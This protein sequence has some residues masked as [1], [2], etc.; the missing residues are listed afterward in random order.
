MAMRTERIL[1][2][3]YVLMIAQFIA[4]FISLKIRLAFLFFLFQ[5][6]AAAWFY[7]SLK[8]ELREGEEFKFYYMLSL[9]FGFPFIGIAIYAQT[10]SA[11]ANRSGSS[12]SELKKSIED[13]IKAEW[14]PYT[15]LKSPQRART[16]QNTAVPIVDLLS[17]ENVDVKRKS[18]IVLHKMR[19]IRAIVLLKHAL[20][21]SNVEIKFM[22]ASAL[23]SIENELK[24][25]IK[26]LE[27]EIEIA[28]SEG[29][30][31]IYELRY[32]LATVISK[33]IKSKL[34]DE[35]SRKALHDQ[36]ISEL[37]RA[38]SENPD[39]LNAK[40]L[41]AEEYS[42][43]GMYQEALGIL[44]E[45]LNNPKVSSDGGE[46]LKISAVTLYCEIYYN[47]SDISKLKEACGSI[48]KYINESLV[49]KYPDLEGF[50]RSV[51]YF[52]GAR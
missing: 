9:V 14:D 20:N 2:Y 18:I 25:K 36:M 26:D 46:K 13:Y 49:K 51:E 37:S 7:F 3:Q 42:L 24:K 34:L 50:Y 39:H 45:I 52:A 19:S 4:A 33:Y 30:D 17:G 23:L 12:E 16:L 22:A 40:M 10:F 38:I 29:F 35:L 11:I 47:I 32:N 1:S 43:K 27:A 6:A 41:L 28:N 15:D 48:K 31:N 8:N 5:I 44:N 21:D